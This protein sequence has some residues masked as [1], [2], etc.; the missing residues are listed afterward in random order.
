MTWTVQPCPLTLSISLAR[1]ANKHVPRT[2]SLTMAMF[3]PL[4]YSTDFIMP[5]GTPFISDI[6]SS[7]A[8]MDEY[9][10]ESCPTNNQLFSLNGIA[11]AFL[12]LSWTIIVIA[13]CSLISSLRPTANITNTVYKQKSANNKR[14]KPSYRTVAARAPTKMEMCR[15]QKNF[16]GSY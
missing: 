16:G 1:P 6:G 3:W 13:L 2:M 7:I 14:E 11:P 9:S 5:R 8:S 10:S 15:L 4:T 12:F